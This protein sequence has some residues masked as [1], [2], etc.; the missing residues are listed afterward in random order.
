M[1]GAGEVVEVA[2]GRTP[3]DQQP[4]ERRGQRQHPGGTCVDVHVEATGPRCTIGLLSHTATEVQA[5]T[6]A[7]ADFQYLQTSLPCCGGTSMCVVCVLCVEDGDDGVCLCH[8]AIAG[9]VGV[10]VGSVSSC[11]EKR[12]VDDVQEVQPDVEALLDFQP[13][14]AQVRYLDDPQEA[15]VVLQRDHMPVRMDAAPV[16]VLDGTSCRILVLLMHERQ[17]FLP[18]AIV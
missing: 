17:Y 1:A 14:A 6:L 3:Q 4:V 18:R 15:L 7:R 2:D 13:S 12:H 10:C 9:H 16:T 11:V 8:D 5:G